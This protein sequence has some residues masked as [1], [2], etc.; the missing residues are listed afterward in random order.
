MHDES[1]VNGAVLTIQRVYGILNFDSQYPFVL[2]SLCILGDSRW[3]GYKGRNTAREMARREAE[4]LGI[5]PY[6]AATVAHQRTLA[7]SN[8]K[9]RKEI[10]AQHEEEYQQALVSIKEKCV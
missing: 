3:R 7:A 6:A 1:D 4:F 2:N 9:R 5:S 8:A 10:Q